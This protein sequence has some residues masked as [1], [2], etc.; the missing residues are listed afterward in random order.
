MLS[1]LHRAEPPLG[2]VRR[3]T[4]VL[5]FVGAVS[6]AGFLAETFLDTELSPWHTVPARLASAGQPYREVF[7]YTDGVAGAAFVLA[8]PSL[9]RIAPVHWPGRLTVVVLF[10]YGLLLLL[11]AAF[12]PQC[13]PEGAGLCAPTGHVGDLLVLAAGVQYVG[14]PLIVGAWWRGRWRVVTR[15]LFVLQFALW[16]AL[17]A[18]GWLLDGRFVGLAARLQTLGASVL[19]GVGAVYILRMGGARRPPERSPQPEGSTPCLG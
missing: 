18:A 1:G 10:G 6:H 17:V 16:A 8:G 14:G 2:A 4:A 19:F 13:L 12:P 7:R 9:F 11:R 5:L 3:L 15:A